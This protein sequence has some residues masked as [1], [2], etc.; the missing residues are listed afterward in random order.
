LLHF[1]SRI[2]VREAIAIIGRA[3]A[4][5]L[6]SWGELMNMN[7]AFHF[8]LA[9]AGL[10][11]MLNLSACGGD[12]DSASNT[13]SDGGAGNGG[14]DAVAMGEAAVKTRVCQSCHGSDLSGST[15]P[16]MNTK[17]YPP[18]ITPDKDT[19]I[20]EWDED[21]IVK[22]ILTGVDDEDAQLCPTMPVF[23]KMGMKDAEAHNI[24][25]YLKSLK[26][27]SK[28]IPESSCPPIKGGEDGGADAGN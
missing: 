26:A 27:V 13:S 5:G 8:G 11:L 19:G 9:S 18:N 28:D 23:G 14:G 6:A 25:K 7:K 1:R 21:T 16:Y 2:A 10:L 20:G 24:A 17:A 22:A 15:T 4:S 3:R 12:D